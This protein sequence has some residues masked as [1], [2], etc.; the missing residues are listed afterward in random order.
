MRYLHGGM[1][2]RLLA[3]LVG[4]LLQGCG[5]LIDAAKL[6]KPVVPE[7]SDELEVIYRHRQV[8]VGIAVE[9]FPP[10]VFPVVWTDQ[11]PRVTGLDIELVQEI[12]WALSGHCIGLLGIAVPHVLRF[13]DL[14]RLLTEG[15][16]DLLLLLVTD[17]VPH[18]S[19]TGLAF[20]SLLL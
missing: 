16:R 9:P 17:N 8:Q 2:G 3:L 15:H 12:T 13:R 11:D 6:L 18:P 14:F 19:T 5:L 7:L 20:S 1:S 10:F 4:Y